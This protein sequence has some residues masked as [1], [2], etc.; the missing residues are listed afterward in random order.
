[1]DQWERIK[2]ERRFWDIFRLLGSIFLIVLC[3]FTYVGYMTVPSPVPANTA[4]WCLMAP[5]F[6]IALVVVLFIFNDH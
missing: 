3:S 6:L 4:M 1:M 5:I 2:Q